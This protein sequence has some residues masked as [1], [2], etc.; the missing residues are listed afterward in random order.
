MDKGKQGDFCLTIEEN[1]IY[2]DSVANN[3]KEAEN[4]AGPTSRLPILKELFSYKLSKEDH[5]LEVGIGPGV[6]YNTIKEFVNPENYVG[7]DISSNMI[8]L[9]RKNT[10]NTIKLYVLKDH[11]L[12]FE[13]N[14]FDKVICYSIFTHMFLENSPPLLG[15][16][17]RV[18]KP[19]GRGFIS[20]FE[21]KQDDY[22]NF[23]RYTVFILGKFDKLL[24]K[25][26]FSILSKTY[27]P[28]GGRKQTVFEVIKE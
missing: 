5:I 25:I 20:I 6:L 9:C 11:N 1:R 21:G 16:I 12:P 24:T 23:K 3:K 10:N 4:R 17:Y 26:G 27:V 28:D 13:D 18:L 2:W 15:E 14:Q 19:K 8:S 7:C 22:S